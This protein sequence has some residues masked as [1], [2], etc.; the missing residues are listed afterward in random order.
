MTLLP[1]WS[2]TQQDGQQ[3]IGCQ[4]PTQPQ[5]G[6]SSLKQEELQFPNKKGKPKTFLKKEEEELWIAQEGGVPVKTEDHEGKPTKSS[7]LHHSPSDE[8]V[9]NKRGTFSDRRQ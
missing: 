8:A 4:G 6:S 1:V 2:M 7:Q 9:M 3:L 5:G